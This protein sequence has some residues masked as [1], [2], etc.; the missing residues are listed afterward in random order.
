MLLVTVDLV[1]IIA[2]LHA[3][4]VDEQDGVLL[5][6]DQPE[7]E[8]RMKITDAI[9]RRV[10]VWQDHTVK[11]S[12]GTAKQ[13]PVN[14]HKQVVLRLEVV[15]KLIEKT[16]FAGGVDHVVDVVNFILVRNEDR[17]EVVRGQ[18]FDVQAL[19]AVCRK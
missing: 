4:R 17:Q 9:L 14:L 18:V 10:V 5:A 2:D 16:P 12:V 19:A 8:V 13:P 1:L 3:L 7:D 11:R 15:L 6:L